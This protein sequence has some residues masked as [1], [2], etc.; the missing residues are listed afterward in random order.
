MGVMGVHTKDLLLFIKSFREY[1]Y[2]W[3]LQYVD[4]RYIIS[5][6]GLNLP[7]HVR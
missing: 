6:F 1:I 2:K 4:I 7:E 3:Q 5:Y